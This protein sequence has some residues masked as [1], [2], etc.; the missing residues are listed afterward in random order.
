MS[1]ALLMGVDLGTSSTK[2]VIIDASGRLLSVATQEYNFDTPRPGWAEQDPEVWLR[3]ALVTMRQATAEADIA[4][5]RITAIGLSGQMH[6][7]VCLSESGQALRPA[8][9]W[10]DQRSGE[11]VARVY[12]EL[13]QERLGEW[14]ANPLA[15]GFMLATWLWLR[16]HE[17]ATAQTTAQLLLPKDYVRYRLTGELGSEPSDACSTLLFDTARRCWSTHLLD[18]LTI[19]AGLLPPIHESADVAGGLR[20]E[21][22][23]ASGLRAGTPVVFGGSD[24]SMQALGNGVVEPGVVLCTIGTGGQLFAPTTMPVYD[25]A[26]RL[27]LFCH[28]MPDC[29]HLMAATLSA[30]LSL[31][32]LRDNV[33]E[34]KSYQALAEM[35]AEAPPGCEG[36]FF[37]PY[38][39]GERTPHMDP[40]A[41]G[42]FIGLSLRTHRGYLV[43]AVM[44]GV[45]LALRQGFELMM[46]LGVPAARVV[47]SGGATGHPLWLQLQA[48][49]LNRPIYQTGTEEAA[50]VGAALLAGVG[51]GIFPDAYAACRGIVRWRDEVVHPIPENASLY[52]AAYE[53]YRQFYPALSAVQKPHGGYEWRSAN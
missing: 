43:R 47:A 19:D 53:S 15:A 48:D 33:F 41:R 22:A 20:A 5:E 40:E 31:R 18:A 35:A 12:Q 8:I 50:A 26:L 46:E 38:L 30:G 27:H 24:Q 17:P 39:A 23:A 51:V 28:A 4:P 10:A 7:A 36:L 37:L 16:E 3:A 32:W 2:T 49:I 21:M 44:E 29:W 9:I 11:Q 45:V 52:D 34:H 14:T 25:R 6:G 13:G 1:S 42:A